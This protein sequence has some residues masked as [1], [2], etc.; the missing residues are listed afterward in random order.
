VLGHFVFLSVILCFISHFVR[1]RAEEAG[2]PTV[3]ALGI[4]GCGPRRWG[5]AGWRRKGRRRER[6]WEEEAGGAHR[7]WGGTG[8]SRK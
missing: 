6:L 3:E 1:R 5:G 4:G 8:R 2:A 7:W